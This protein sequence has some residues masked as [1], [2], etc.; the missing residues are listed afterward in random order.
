[1]QIDGGPPVDGPAGDDALMNE[2]VMHTEEEQN[3]VRGGI[4]APPVDDETELEFD[5]PNEEI[6]RA[7][8]ALFPKG[9]D[10]ELPVLNWIADEADG[11][12]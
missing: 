8:E 5:W 9:D 10:A 2:S 3:G 11:G 1:M 7:C 6:K 12:Q 4:E